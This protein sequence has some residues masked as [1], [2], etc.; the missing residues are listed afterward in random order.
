MYNKPK[1]SVII[2]VYNVEKY[3]DR[4]ITSV[5]NQTFEDIEILCVD[6]CSLDNSYKIVEK[7]AA[8]DSRVHLIR[9]SKNMG[10]GG[11]RNTALRIA[12]ADYI[13]SVDS[14]DYMLPN[15]LQRLWEETENGWFDVVTCGF[16]R[17]DENG[18]IIA[19]QNY[20]VATFLNDDNNINIFSVVNP[21]FWNKLWRKSL[22][23]ENDIFFPVNL[24][25]EDVPTT[26]QLLSKAKYIKV[27]KDRLYQYF[28]RQDSIT[29]SYSAKHILDYYEGF[30]ILLSFLERNGLIER[31]KDEFIEYINSNMRFHSDNVV[32]STMVKGDLEQYLRHMLMFKIA[33]MENRDFLKYKNLGDLLVLLRQKNVPT[34]LEQKK[35]EMDILENEKVKLA[36]ELSKFKNLLNSKE[37]EVSKYQGLFAAKKQEFSQ[38]E[39][40]IKA[41]ILEKEMILTEVASLKNQLGSLEKEKKTLDTE[42]LVHLSKQDALA[43]E[44][45]SLKVEMAILAEKIKKLELEKSEVISCWQTLGLSGFALF[46]RPFCTKKQYI[47]LQQQPRQF[48]KDSRNKVARF[49][50]SVLGVL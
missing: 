28:I 2:P 8:E 39:K 41:L 17:V 27:I 19:F 1:I 44:S 5:R 9:H 23:T 18:N 48:F 37:K 32:G 42:V 26:P 46:M 34:A 12:N 4:C 20:P 31:Y 21:A 14:D 10:L 25:F 49:I 50:G 24:Y 43:K 7:H 22:F 6:D 29:T 30:E 3:I 15:M 33:F 16:N 11:A 35:K 47:K 36:D 13:A 45:S 40:E 38:K